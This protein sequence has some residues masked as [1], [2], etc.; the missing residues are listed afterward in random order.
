MALPI[1]AHEFSWVHADREVPAVGPLDLHIAAGE[2]VLLLGPS[3]A[4]KTTLL[5]AIAGVLPTESG[6]AVG[7][8]LIGDR[9]PDP[10]RGEVGL[11]LQDPDSQVIFS[12]VGDDVAF[13][14][15]N[16]GLPA[17]AIEAQVT[18][19]LR[20]MGLELG[21]DHPT[22]ALSGGQKQRLA[23]A[24]IHAM[25]PQVIILDEPTANIDPDSATAVRDAVLETQAAASA[26]MLIVE[27]RVSLWLDHVDTVIVLGP[28]GLLTQGPPKQIF[29][30]PSLAEAL[31]QCG[32]WVP[33][34]SASMTEDTQRPAEAGPRRLLQP[35]GEVALRT[36]QLDVARPGARIP[37]ATEIELSIRA[38]EAVGIV[39]ANGTGKSTTALTLA[40][41]IPEFSGAVSALGT[42]RAGAKHA[43]PY[44][45]PSAFLAPRIGM[46]FQE[47]EHQFLRSSVAEE[48]ALGPRLASWSSS[49]IA[50]RVDELLQVLGLK[51]LAEAHPQ[52]LSGGEKRRLSVAAMM[53]PRP[54]VLIVDEPTFGQDA[55]T[56]AGL[57]ELFLDVL[58]RGSTVVA[59]SH[60]HGFLDAIGA[61]RVV[62]DHGED[63]VLEASGRGGRIE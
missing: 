3:G 22:A 38:G 13:G 56:W 52:G 21:H 48:L 20:A 14:M 29:G 9:S 37:A 43:R 7:Q 33:K 6:E 30:D 63:P 41:L 11:V 58:K 49:Q 12:R 36:E 46:V 42:L 8:L 24:G 27:H 16:L 1:V 60:D 10:R 47:P 50:D 19:S 4:G 35:P 31:A 59:I 40:G 25:A 57:V 26:T 54:Q 45:W 5:H 51:H 55:L 15:E 61:R 62:L 2:K 32:I 28:N 34:S 18:S 23:L 44:R 17:E 39:G 53:A